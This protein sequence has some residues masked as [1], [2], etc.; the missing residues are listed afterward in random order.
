MHTHY[1]EKKI[2]DNSL[3]IRNLSMKPIYFSMLWH[4]PPFDF[5]PFSLLSVKRPC[6]QVVSLSTER[7][8]V[9]HIGDPETLLKKEKRAVL[10]I[11]ADTPFLTMLP[12]IPLNA[13][14]RQ[15]TFHIQFKFLET[16]QSEK[17]PENRQGAQVETPITLIQ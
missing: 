14:H 5:S 15:G 11:S 7:G 6:F 17:F 4:L 12:A 3:D 13:Q 2:T 1:Q 8:F 16:A 10:F 9:L